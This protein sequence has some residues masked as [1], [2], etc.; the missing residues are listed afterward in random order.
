MEALSRFFYCGSRWKVFILLLDA[1]SPKML[2]MLW[3]MMVPW[4][5]GIRDYVSW[6]RRECLCFLRMRW[7]HESLVCTCRS[8]C[9]SLR[10]HN[11]WY[12]SSLPRLLGNLRY[13]I[14]YTQMC[15]AQWRQNILAANH[16][17]TFIDEHSRKLLLFPM[18]TKDQVMGY[19]K[20][21]VALV[22]RQMGKKLRCIRSENGG[23]YSRPFD[24]YCKEHGIMH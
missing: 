14:W 13:W 20:H 3:R 21:F 6:V 7:F 16:F 17:L 10:K 23:E 4:S 12:F 11:T 24:A 2:L 1:C 19:F 8:V 9:I 5:Y 18:R 22:E 15:V